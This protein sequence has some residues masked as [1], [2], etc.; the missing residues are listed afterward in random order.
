M[1]VKWFKIIHVKTGNQFYYDRPSIEF[2]FR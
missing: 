1:P 2:V